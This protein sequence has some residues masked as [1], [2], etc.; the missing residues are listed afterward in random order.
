MFKKYHHTLETTLTIF[1]AVFFTILLTQTVWAQSAND[2]IGQQLYHAGGATGAGFQPPTDIRFYVATIIRWILSLVGT[3]LFIL[4]L[5]AGYLWMTAGGNSEQVD[6]AKT[7]LRNSTIGLIIVLS[8]YAI[9]IAVANVARGYPVGTGTGFWG[10]VNT[11][12]R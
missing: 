5:Y 6:Q 4:N 12:A 2:S 3:V 1:M 9:T 7:T 10:F 11:M 8:S